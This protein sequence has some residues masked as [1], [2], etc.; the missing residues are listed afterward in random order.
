LERLF[1]TKELAPW[2]YGDP[3][4]QEAPADGGIDLDPLFANADLTDLTART[5][6]DLDLSVREALIASDL[7]P[8][9]GKS[10]HAFC[11]SIDRAKD[12]RVLCNNQP[13]ERWMSTMLHEFG[14]AAYDLSIDPTLPYLLRE[15]AHIFTTEGVA[16]LFGRLVHDATWLAM[17]GGISASEAQALSAQARG[18]RRGALLVFAR[19]GLVMAHFEAALYDDPQRPDL[20]SLWWDLVERFQGVHRPKGRASPDWAAKI[21]LAVAPVYYHNYLLGELFASQVAH[22]LGTL[23]GNADAGRFLRERVFR[24]G[25]LHR[26]DDLV[27][28]SL[29]HPLSTRAWAADLG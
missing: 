9:N 2:H 7:D 11:V 29:G 15:P 28:R 16:M 1:S 25:S 12:V 18:A 13:N 19:W 27:E 21:H 14:H 6:D 20:D 22:A 24:P 4:F 17:Y 26:W 10:Q 23:A 5:Y 3:F 8:R